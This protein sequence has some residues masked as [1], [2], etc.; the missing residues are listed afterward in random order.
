MIVWEAGNIGRV[1]ATEVE[2]E[3]IEA[4]KP[5]EVLAT[6]VVCGASVEES[7]PRSV[8]TVASWAS[9]VEVAAAG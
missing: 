6:A 3:R 5:S 9:G 7:T 2:G 8:V 4:G 1:L